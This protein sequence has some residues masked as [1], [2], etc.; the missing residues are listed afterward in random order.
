MDNEQLGRYWMIF[1][2]VALVG[3]GLLG[4]VSGNPIASQD[5][6]AIFRVNAAHNVVHLLTG[7]IALGIGFGTRGMDL[8]NGLI[9][10]GALYALVAVLLLIDPALFGLFADAPSNA[11]DMVLHVALAVVSLA[12]GYMLRQRSGSTAAAR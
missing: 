9:G 3:A 8:A 10:F 2:G 12:L 1:A 7:A 6:A 4:F 11:G 5:P